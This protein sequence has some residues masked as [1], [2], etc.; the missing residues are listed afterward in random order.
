MLANVSDRLKH[1]FFDGSFCQA[2][3]KIS[4]QS[5]RSYH[6]VGMTLKSA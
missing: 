2:D 4:Y 1:M 3:R 6:S 5:G